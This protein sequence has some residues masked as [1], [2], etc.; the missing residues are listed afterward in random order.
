MPD[1]SVTEYASRR[2]LTADE[3]RA[4]I[5]SAAR[6]EF[7]RAGYHGASTASIA[8][9]AGCSEPMLYKHF[10][11]KHALFV[12]VLEHVSGIVEDGFDRVLAAPGDLLVNLREFL[13]LVMHDPAYVESLQLRKLAVTLAHEPAVH[14]MLTDLQDRHEARVC[15]AIDRAKAEGLVREDVEAADVA[16]TWTGLM[17][18]GCYREAL[19]PGGFAAMLPTVED[20]IERLRR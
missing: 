20:F 9:A 2:R 6:T 19:A 8:R 11:G 5:L 7:A 17:M 10:V 12:A 16:W 15:M 4:R 14:Q 3:R 1:A 18:A 13:P